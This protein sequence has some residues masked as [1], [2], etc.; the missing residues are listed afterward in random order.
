MPRARLVGL[1]V[2]ALLILLVMLYMPTP[3]AA[4]ILP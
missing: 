3:E 4:G 1:V 2:L